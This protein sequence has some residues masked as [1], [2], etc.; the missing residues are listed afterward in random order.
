MV[1]KATEMTMPLVFGMLGTALGMI[2]VFWLDAVLLAWGAAL[3]RKD[4]L[5]VTGGTQPSMQTGVP[6]AG[7]PR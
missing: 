7:K 1:N 4:V 6:P 2:P 5:R 3:M